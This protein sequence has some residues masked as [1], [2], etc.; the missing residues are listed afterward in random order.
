MTEEILD[1]AKTIQ[2]VSE[3]PGIRSCLLSTTQGKKL[4]GRLVGPTKETAISPALPRLFQELKSTLGEA[5]S[6]GG[7]TLYFDQEPLSII[8]VNELCLIV[9]HDNRPFRPGVREK[10]FSVMQELDEISDAK[11]FGAGR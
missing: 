10:I 11:I 9:V 6:L 1:L 4:A 5:R 3:L 7:I 2:K 8:L